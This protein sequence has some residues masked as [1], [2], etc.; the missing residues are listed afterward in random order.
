M[1]KLLTN[2]TDLQEI[3]EVLQTKAAG[4]VLPELTNEGSASDLLNGEQLID[5]KGKVITGTMP[6]NGTISSTM[7]GINTKSVAIPQGYTSGGTVSLDNTIDNEVDT[8]ADLISQIVSTLENKA[9]E[10]KYKEVEYSE[11]EDD[12]ID[13]SISSYTND[14]VKIIRS[15]AFGH[16]TSITTVNFPVCTNIDSYAFYRC[17]SLTTVSF[18]AC[19]GIEY[20]AFY[21][22]NS[23]K[24]VNFPACTA[25]GNYA[26]QYCSSLTSISFPACTIINNATF[27]NCTS[28]TSVNFPACHW[29]GTAAFWNCFNLT[30]VNLYSCA[31]IWNNTFKNCYNLSSIMLTSK[32]CCQLA[33]SNAFS[34]TPYAGY[35]A[36]FSGTPYIYVP[37]S[38]ITKYQSATN[39]A[40]FSS[41]FSAI[42][43]AN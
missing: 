11:N 24:S 1:S 31:S 30:A 10:V 25:I 27:S 8:Q 40:Y 18:P 42:E 3:L 5:S 22:C 19:T 2:T 21:S 39:W 35:S 26:F 38:L 43:D 36:S 6:N 37:A 12:I 9:V 29:V 20:N 13:G 4:T 33:A 7:D 41:Y 28:L 17:N 16:C 14:R 34:S 32:Y 23:L 15:Y